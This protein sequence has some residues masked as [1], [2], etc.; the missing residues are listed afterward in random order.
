[1]MFSSAGAVGL[2]TPRNAAVADARAQFHAAGVPC[3]DTPEEA[4]RAFS[5]LTTFRANQAAL[6]DWA[7]A[8]SKQMQPKL[9]ADEQRIVGPMN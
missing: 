7:R 1:M 8:V 4:V 2:V 9:V 3:Y 6:L 5:L